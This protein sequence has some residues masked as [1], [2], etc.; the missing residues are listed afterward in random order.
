MAR[1]PQE[2]ENVKFDNIRVGSKSGTGLHG[3]NTTEAFAVEDM[4]LKIGVSGTRTDG[5]NIKSEIFV[6]HPYAWLNMKIKAA[7]DWLRKASSNP[8]E[9]HTF[10]VYM[11]TAMLTEFE[12]E[13]ASE[14]A[15]KYASHPIAAENKKFAVELYGSPDSAGC[16]EAARQ[17][18]KP[19]DYEVFWAAL[20]Q[21]LGINL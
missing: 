16:R 5:T 2:D 21:V 20:R 1:S 10:D 19:L 17:A 15:L 8:S 4:P 3:R 9:K 14:L 6:P 7:H 13:T 11:L 18:G 12:I